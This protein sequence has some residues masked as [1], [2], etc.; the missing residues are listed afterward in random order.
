MVLYLVLAVIWV[1]ALTPL[2]LRKMSERRVTT[3]VD[4]FRR[5]LRGL[6]RAYPRL[7]ASAAHPDMVLSMSQMAH[8]G[9]RTT[10]MASSRM[11]NGYDDQYDSGS[12]DWRG[13][14]GGGSS[15]RT[16]YR[17][18]NASRPSSQAARRRQVLLILGGTL[19]GSFL[20][21][22]ISGLSF[23]WDLLLLALAATA[24]YVALLIHFHR[25]AVEREHKVVD[26]YEAPARRIGA[27]IT[28]YVPAR[29]VT[30]DDY[31]DEQGYLDD[32]DDPGH[33][34]VAAGDR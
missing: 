11:S 20:L 17:S 14:S 24:G 9:P 16:T 13:A 26:L 7:A 5:Q 12:D 34:A 29:T 25:V 1:A 6:R 8:R 31:G 3:S 21:G 32:E 23:F 10:M 18:A 33:D 22:A 2:I 19:I 4:S 27:P 15:Q 28:P 30:D